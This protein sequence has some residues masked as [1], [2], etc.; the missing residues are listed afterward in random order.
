M[1]LGEVAVIEGDSADSSTNRMLERQLVG[2]RQSD[3]GKVEPVQLEHVALLQGAPNTPPGMVRLAANAVTLRAQA[4]AHME[5]ETRR[6]V[7]S[8]REV[9]RAGL[10]DRRKRVGLNFNL[11][12]ADV[13]KRRMELSRDPEADAEELEVVKQAQ[14]SSERSEGWRLSDLMRKWIGSCRG[15]CV[16]WRTS[17]PSRQP[18]MRMWKHSM[19]RWRRSPCGSHRSGS[20][21]GTPP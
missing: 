20:G 4:E 3:D 10:P 17:S 6:L 21:G 9:V 8:R 16:F 2:L 15:T 7:E 14:R 19:P 1:H 5:G 13:A 11:K 18:A 12:S